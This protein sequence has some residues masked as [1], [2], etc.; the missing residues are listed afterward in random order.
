MEGPVD[1]HL[2]H[3]GWRNFYTQMSCPERLREQFKA[4]YQE[5]YHYA[6]SDDDTDKAIF[7]KRNLSSAGYER[8][9]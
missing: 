4:T 3:S 2:L 1:E 5:I 8:F 6:I 9:I 7:L